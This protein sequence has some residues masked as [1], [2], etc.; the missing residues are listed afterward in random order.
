[1]IQMNLRKAS[2]K[3]AKGIGLILSKSYN[4][5]SAKEG[6]SV[7]RGELKKRHFFFVSV[8]GKQITGIV[9]FIVHGLP[10][11][12]LCELDRIAVLP[13]YRGHG[14]AHDIFPFGVQKMQ[15]FYKSKKCRLRKLYLLTHKSNL[16]AQKFYKKLGFKKETILK[17]HYYKGEPELV[18]SRFY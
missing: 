2:F 14:V 13:E 4:I 8:Y 1:M 3:D 11:H 15:S 12:G 18:M 16:R 5:S 7:F 9:S 6:A 10:K 17:D